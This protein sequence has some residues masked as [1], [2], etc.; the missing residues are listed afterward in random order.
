[1]LPGSKNKKTFQMNKTV[2]WILIVVGA[3]IVIM[4][5]GKLLMGGDKS[6]GIKVSTEKAAKRTIIETVN[7]S[8]KIYP[9]VEVKISPDISGEITE[10]NVEEG[11]TVKSGQVLARI[12]ADIYS[13]QKDEAA[14]RV[15][16]TEATVANSQAALEALKA[17]LDQAKQNLDRNKTLFDQKVISK[18]ELEQFETTYRSALA[19]YNAAQQNIKS[20]MATVQSS[21]TGLTKAN[22]DLGRT[23]LVAPMNGVISSLKVKKGERVSGN[24][25]T[26][27]TEMMTVSDMSVLEVRVDIGENDI[28]KINIGDSADIEVDAYNN[29]KFKGIVTKIASS[30]KTNAASLTSNDVTN[31]EVR[32]RLDKESYKDLLIKAFPFRP[33]MNASADIMTRRHDNVLSVPINA[34]NAR[35]KG[36]DKNLAEKQKEDK[37]MKEEATDETKEETN[38]ASDELE[39]VA[40]VLQKDGKVKKVVVRTAIQDMSYIEI[41]SGL[42][43]GD[44]VVVGPYTAISKTLK[45]GTKVKVVPKDKLFQN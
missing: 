18:S 21:Q 23:T 27:G 11:D 28:V 19:N 35:V 8:G 22:K 7:A 36:S 25:F 9:E 42:N 44:E 38:S 13:L 32:I 4:V 37:K 5:A 24:S 34:V 1:V 15:S 29:R 39:E 30:T 6:G 40:F 14:S 17:S 3:V 43:E 26:V 10:L 45:D 12:Y 16:Q 2:K 33:G 31:Y 20:L 41:S